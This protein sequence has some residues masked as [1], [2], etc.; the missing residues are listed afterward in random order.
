[1]SKKEKKIALVTGGAGFIG[2]HLVDFLLRKNFEVRVV[3]N[4]T[5]GRRKNFSHNLKN[6]NFK[7]KKIDINKIN[8]NEKF[9]KKVK[10]VYHLAG[11]GDIVPSIEMPDKYIETN[12]IGTLKVLEASRFNKVKKFI[13][14]ASS[15][16]YGM[17]NKRTSENDLISP[18]YPY[19][20]SKNL[21][22]QIA[23][24]W[25][26]VYKLPV[27]SIR[28]FNAYGPRVRTTGAYGAVFGVFF[29]QKLS[30]SPI[31]IVGNGKQSRDFIYVSD[32]VNAFYKAST[33][34]NS[35]QI[36]NL[37]NDNPRTV[38]ELANLIGGKKTYIPERPGEPKITWAN[39]SKIKKEL[40]WKPKIKFKNGVKMMLE[41]IHLERCPLWNKRTIKKQQNM[42]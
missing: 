8:R 29:K 39:I 24:H 42:V 25:H 37:G 19:A 11:I 1:M 28:I 41:N 12:A 27:N 38:N 3:D 14:A 16:C 17:N 26:K 10:F 13:Y 20:L 33:T 6:K 4:L 21:G 36:Y 32:V 5:G 9:F 31:T 35:G 2:S 23:L 34:S 18:E 15:S 7:F 40:N 30:G 22:E